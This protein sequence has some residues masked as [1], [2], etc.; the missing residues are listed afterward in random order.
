MEASIF[1]KCSLTTELCS[2]I[3]ELLDE[4]N[5]HFFIIPKKS[6]KWEKIELFLYKQLLV[7]M[8]EYNINKKF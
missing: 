5:K 3:I 6:D 7:N 1:R 2:D 4:S 8:N